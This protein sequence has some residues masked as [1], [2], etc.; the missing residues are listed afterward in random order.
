[1]IV[2]DRISSETFFFLGIRDSR[3]ETAAQAGAGFCSPTSLLSPL[4]GKFDVPF[5]KLRYDCLSSTSLSFESALTD[6]PNSSD[7]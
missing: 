1:V 2:G 7:R 6:P 3:N 4:L 5:G